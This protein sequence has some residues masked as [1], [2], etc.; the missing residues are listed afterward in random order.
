MGLLA[1]LFGGDKRNERLAA[2]GK[3]VPVSDSQRAAMRRIWEA[4]KSKS[5]P[6]GDPLKDIDADDL[7]YVLKICGSGFRPSE[8]GNADVLRLASWRSLKDLGFSA[9]EA[10]VAVGMMFNFVGRDD[11]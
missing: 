3:T 4:V 1:R 2:W 7:T 6:K 9:D 8:F 10:T 11:V 5:A